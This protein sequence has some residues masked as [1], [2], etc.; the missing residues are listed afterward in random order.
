MKLANSRKLYVYLFIIISGIILSPFFRSGFYYI[1]LPYYYVLSKTVS[2]TDNL[3]DY[4]ASKK[5]LNEKIRLLESD[6]QQLIQ[7]LNSID[8]STGL[9]AQ[10]IGKNI[11]SKHEL[12]IN[13]GYASGASLDMIV[14]YEGKLIGKITQINRWSSTVT[15]V[16]DPGSAIIAETLSDRLEGVVQGSGQ[17]LRADFNFVSHHLDV[18]LNEPVFSTG[19]GLSCPVRLLI[20]YIN[21]IEKN[22]IHQSIKIR[23]AVDPYAIRECQLFTE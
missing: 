6:Q 21:N 22:G 23:L 4:I 1:S 18:K 3:F 5:K 12:I 8:I 11:D 20:G 7:R 2:F 10:V 16:S 15:L 17:L 13:K 14:A 9:S 19:E